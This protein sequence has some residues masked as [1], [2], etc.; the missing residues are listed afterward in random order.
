MARTP[1]VALLTTGL[2]VTAPAAAQATVTLSVSP[3]GANSGNSCFSRACRTLPHAI[4]EAPA[5][6]TVRLAAGTY[7]DEI[8][9]RRDVTLTGPSTGKATLGAAVIVAHG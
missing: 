9:L 1:W 4:A 5:G 6:A 7:D 8:E 2:A 3:A